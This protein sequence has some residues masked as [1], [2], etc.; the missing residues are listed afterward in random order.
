M[1][2]IYVYQN[3]TLVILKNLNDHYD[4][5]FIDT[6]ECDDNYGNCLENSNCV[7]NLGSFVCECQRSYEKING[8]CTG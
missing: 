3:S 8:E 4:F 6:N 7:N 2:Q 1:K 5:L